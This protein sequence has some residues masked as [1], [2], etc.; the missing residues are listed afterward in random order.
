[1]VSHKLDWLNTK[2][3]KR[4][5]DEKP[6]ILLSSFWPFLEKKLAE[7]NYDID[8]SLLSEDNLM[9]VL[10]GLQS[11]KFVILPDL[12][13]RAIQLFLEPNF[14]SEIS[15]EYLD[16][17]FNENTIPL[18]NNAL[19]SLQLLEEV[20]SSQ[21]ASE[22]LKSLFQK[23]KEQIKSLKKPDMFHSLRYSLTGV[24]EGP[25]I[26]V[27]IEILGRKRCIERVLKSIEHIKTSKQLNQ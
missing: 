3:I 27:I 18:L 26:P 11:T 20:P 13:E 22:L 21:D 25:E 4:L 24:K 9:R 12:A 16:H 10:K 1:M 7:G 23:S 15:K 8:R 19:E 5:S 2:H 17:L 14:E 6:D